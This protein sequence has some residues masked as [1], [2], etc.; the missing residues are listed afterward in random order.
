ME[1]S[2]RTT[3]VRNSEA[4]GVLLAVVAEGRVRFST[5]ELAGRGITA[6]AAA[7]RWMLEVGKRSLPGAALADKLIYFAELTD[8]LVEL[9]H[10]YQD[11]ALDLDSF[12]ADLAEV[13]VAME[14]WPIHSQGSESSH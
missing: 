3:P 13:V 10:A 5:V 1:S 2:G 4:L 11:G 12:E 6:G 8:R 14:N 7:T 9:W